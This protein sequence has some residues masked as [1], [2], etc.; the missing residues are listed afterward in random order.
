[1][2][3]KVLGSWRQ[4]LQIALTKENLGEFWGNDSEEGG[5]YL[6]FGLS[7]EGEERDPS[8]MCLGSCQIPNVGKHF[9]MFDWAWQNQYLDCLPSFLHKGDWKTCNDPS[10][11]EATG[12]ITLLW[13]VAQWHPLSMEIA[14][15]VLT[16]NIVMITE[17]LRKRVKI[18][19]SNG[20]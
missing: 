16:M 15:G 12:M 8:H 6:L 17:F 9:R 10:P 4:R 18:N 11:K 19:W 20:I 13:E 1:M 3:R 7:N 14:V 5:L 2:R